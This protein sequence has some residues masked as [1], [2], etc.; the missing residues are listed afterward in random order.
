MCLT[1]L[2]TIPCAAHVPPRFKGERKAEAT[3]NMGFLQ[4]S[5]HLCG[6]ASKIVR[7]NNV[8]EP[9]KPFPGRAHPS[10]IDPREPK[11]AQEAPQTS[12]EVP[13][14]RSREPKSC[15]TASKGRPSGAQELPKTAPDP[16]KTEPGEPQNEFLAQS[17]W[18][19]VCDKLLQ[20]FFVVFWLVRQACDV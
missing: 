2:D 18:E 8:L 9:P 6:Q 16:S 14:R 17:L 20:R 1:L 15:P 19:A 12:P 3:G 4:Q 13:K 7:K 11:S 5:M 10:K